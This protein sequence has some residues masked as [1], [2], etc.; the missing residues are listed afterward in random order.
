MGRLIPLVL[1][2]NA[3]RTLA[4]PPL[5][6]SL[7]RSCMTCLGDV[8]AFPYNRNRV[9]ERIT[10]HVVFRTRFRRKQ[11]QA[12]GLNRRTMLTWHNV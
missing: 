4:K 1:A 2:A 5:T 10:D 7:I 12:S 8:N 6:G 9:S 3:A 11:G